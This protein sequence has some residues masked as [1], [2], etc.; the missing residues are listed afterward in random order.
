MDIN[1]TKSMKQ[2]NNPLEL[3]KVI[4]EAINNN[5]SN[6]LHIKMSCEEDQNCPF[7]AALK[8]GNIA[9]MKQGEIKMCG[10]IL[11]NQTMVKISADGKV[12]G[13]M[14]QFTANSPLVI[15][16]IYRPTE[17]HY[18]LHDYRNMQLVWKRPV[19][20]VKKS[21][22]EIEEALGLTPGSLEIN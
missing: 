2:I 21:M 15:E 6:P 5:E 9:I 8:P 3:I 17:E 11:P 18:A 20:K 7:E 16:A 10:I 12:T 13:Y 4:A 22:R 19:D 1:Y 14:S